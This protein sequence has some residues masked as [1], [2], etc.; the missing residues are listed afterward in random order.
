MKR[1]TREWGLFA[2]AA[3]ALTAS[4][5]LC[6]RVLPIASSAAT[7]PVRQTPLILIDAGHGGTDGGAVASDGTLEKDINLDV[8]L[9]LYDFLRF[10]GYAVQMTRT[11]DVSLHD[12]EADTVRERKVSDMHHRLAL[13]DEADLVI[14]IHQ[15]KFG[16]AS[17]HGAQLF[18]S[19]NHP[20]S[21]AVAQTLRD[22]LYRLLQPDN[23]R[24]LKKGDDAIFLLYKT[25]SPAV[26]VECGFLS[27]PEERAR[28]CED[29]YRRELAFSLAC[30]VLAYA[31]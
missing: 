10:F 3:A 11:E 29:A 24:E 2:T 23:T 5:C 16:Q 27:N 8:S 6:V 19:P 14:S 12:A 15:N 17:C 20:A 4:V 26:L 21:E 28:L 31:P 13:Y 18:Y 7:Q 30:G 9:K 25:V 1:R 22:T